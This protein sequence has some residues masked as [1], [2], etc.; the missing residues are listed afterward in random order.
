M[1]GY[2]WSG[3]VVCPCLALA[4]GL[5]ILPEAAENIP[6]TFSTHNSDSS[7]AQRG[8]HPVRLVLHPGERRPVTA[9][10]SGKTSDGDDVYPYTKEA[11][12]PKRDLLTIKHLV[13]IKAFLAEPGHSRW[14]LPLTSFPVAQDER[15]IPTTLGLIYKPKDNDC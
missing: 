7:K 11:W 14:H 4:N 5:H 6:D 13:C 10:E 12:L 8:K 3:W 9:L 15:F 1:L 2:S